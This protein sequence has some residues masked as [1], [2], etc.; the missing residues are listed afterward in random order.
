MSTLTQKQIDRF[1]DDGFLVV[2]DL[3]SPSEVDRLADAARAEF[4]AHRYVPGT[5][6]FPTPAT[7][8]LSEDNLQI[9]DVRFVV[10]HP[11][12]VTGVAELLGP[13]I[14]LSAFAL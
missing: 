13:E 5:V 9:A 3:L 1:H 2:P 7:Y 4:E 6:R 10:D 14:C 12:I 11:R 8:L